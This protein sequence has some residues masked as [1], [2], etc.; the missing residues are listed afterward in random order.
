MIYI[1]ALTVF[2]FRI[3]LCFQGKGDWMQMDNP[4]KLFHYLSGRQVT[5][6]TACIR[7]ISAD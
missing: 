4:A 5:L 6:F 7:V 2:N 3:F 1:S